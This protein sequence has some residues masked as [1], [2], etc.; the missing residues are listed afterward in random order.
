[1]DNKKLYRSGL[2]YSAIVLGFIFSAFTLN[3][4]RDITSDEVVTHIK[5]LASDELEGRFPGTHGDSMAE[6]YAVK[7]FESYGLVPIAEDGYR[8]HFS[9]VTEI[10]A[11][12]QNS[13]LVEI[14]GNEKDVNKLGTDFYP[15]NSC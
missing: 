4:G 10:Q 1:M 9:F 14:D 12:D 15:I 8:Q 11:G 7:L 3:G 13:L 5:Y 6:N 2:F